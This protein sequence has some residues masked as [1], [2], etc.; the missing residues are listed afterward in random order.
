MIIYVKT[1]W[2]NPRVRGG[3]KTLKI[4]SLHKNIGVGAVRDI[5]LQQAS[6]KYIMFIDGDD[7]IASDTV[8]S[9]VYLI[10][11]TNSDLIEF[12]YERTSD[13]SVDIKRKEELKYTIC[14]DAIQI[15]RLSNHIACNK[16][17]RTKIIKNHNI[18]FT[19]RFL[20]DTLFTRQYA[21]LCSRA[22]FLSNKFY[23]YFCNPSSLT[24][25]IELN[26]LSNNDRTDEV[27]K[28]YKNNGLHEQKNSFID[29]SMK[30][31][32]HHLIVLSHSH[33]DVFRFSNPDS[34]YAT[35]CKPLIELFNR[36]AILFRLKAYTIL[37][38]RSSVKIILKHGI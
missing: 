32:I 22:V 12:G 17:Y 26:K 13:E 3:G 31:L 16:L 23:Y 5:G 10:E 35:V 7:W 21:L 2:R 6:G 25:T 20:E 19:H 15:E 24:S 29:N 33:H 4:T 9:C 1:P 30:F 36:S 11:E 38:L 27:I 14:D 34:E 18:K 8:Y 28:F 37:G